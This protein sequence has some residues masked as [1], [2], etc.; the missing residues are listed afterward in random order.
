MARA[1]EVP[2]G[3]IKTSEGITNRFGVAIMASP[4][5]CGVGPGFYRVE[6]TKTDEKIPVRY[7]TDTQLGLEV[8]PNA[9]GN[10]PVTFDLR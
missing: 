7:N 1:G 4:A 2:G 5:G 6:I 10:G 9:L 3:A 8:A